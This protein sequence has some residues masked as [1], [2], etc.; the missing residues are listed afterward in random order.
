MSR[1]TT[2]LLPPHTYALFKAFRLPFR[3]MT[4]CLTSLATALVRLII[5]AQV[6]LWRQIAMLH[7]RPFFVNYLPDNLSTGLA[8]NK[9]LQLPKFRTPLPLHSI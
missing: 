5:T 6:S 7:L 1:S 9:R 2:T 4:T 8:G 3:V